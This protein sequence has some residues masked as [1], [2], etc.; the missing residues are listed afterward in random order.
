MKIDFIKSAEK[1]KLLS[2]LNE[3]FG[4]TKLPYLLIEAGK[5]KVRAFSGSLSKEEMHNLGRITKIETI[6]IYF[7][8]KET[9]IRLSFDA[10]HLI[11]SQIIKNIISLN[12]SMALKWLHGEDL[13]IKKPQGT[14][15]ISFNNDFI[16]LGKSN[17]E[18][19]LNHVSKDRRLKN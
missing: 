1:K 16:G 18:K 14:Y 15:I 6:G 17:S 10:P 12:E 3:Q 9:P 7:L 11:P 4:I 19:I 5:G 13:Q 2:Q 8:V